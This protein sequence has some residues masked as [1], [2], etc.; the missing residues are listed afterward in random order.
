MLICCPHCHRKNRLEPA[1]LDANPTCGACK[2]ALFTGQPLSL[3]STTFAK[4]ASA[5]LPMVIDF[6]ASW[7]GPCQ[8]FAPVFAKAATAFE[9]RARL[10]KV[11]TETAPDLAARFAIRSIPTLLILHRGQAVARLN[12]AVPPQ[13]FARWL[14]THLPAIT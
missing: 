6:W 1:R 4:H 9:P 3:S 8:Q 14:D 7:C 12:G 13:E 11:D 2:Q 5:D 10:A